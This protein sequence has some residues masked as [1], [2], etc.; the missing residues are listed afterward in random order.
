MKRRELI[1]KLQEMGCVIVRHGGAH[2][3]YTNLETKQSQPVPRHN[4]IS[5]NL[6]KSIIKKLSNA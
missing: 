4:E 3:W 1:K 2:D 6:A 5:E